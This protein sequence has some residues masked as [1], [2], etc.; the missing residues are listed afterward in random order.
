I[1]AELRKLREAAP[2]DS[3]D[4]R[5]FNSVAQKY[6]AFAAKYPDTL[7]LDYILG[8]L[9][10]VKKEARQAL[11]TVAAQ[12][13]EQGRYNSARLI[14]GRLLE[15]HPEA[16]SLHYNLGQACR[17]LEQWEPAIN[18]FEAARGAV[19]ANEA[20][21]IDALLPAMRQRMEAER[22][23]ATEFIPALQRKDIDGAEAALNKVL[24]ADD[25][26]GLAWYRLALVWQQKASPEYRRSHPGLDPRDTQIEALKCLTIAL[27]LKPR[28]DYLMTRAKLYESL[29]D[30]QN[31]VG[32]YTT[33][34]GH[35]ESWQVVRARAECY[36][37]LANDDAA[38]ADFRRVGELNPQLKAAM[39]HE[40]RMIEQ[41]R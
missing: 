23:L 21:V 4:T 32:D 5:Y 35:R 3:Y 30:F 20:A 39:D 9:G 1:E 11:L 22:V 25:Q 41:N 28:P 34:I 16:L 40:I 37:R 33:L 14:W 29:R 19:Q 31:A 7:Y 12:A 17:Q 26:Y 10:L 24:Q 38:I 8:K 36:R 2:A 6:A 13:Y 15:W 18:H 27:R